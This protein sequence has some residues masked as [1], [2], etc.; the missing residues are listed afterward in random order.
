MNTEGPELPD[1]PL[2]S[3]LFILRLHIRNTLTGWGTTL[4]C[5][6]GDTRLRGEGKEEEEEEEED[7]KGEGE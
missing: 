3:D 6:T 7:G 5:L 1:V 2:C 4:L